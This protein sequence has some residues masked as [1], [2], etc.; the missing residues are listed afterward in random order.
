VNAIEYYKLKF[1]SDRNK[2]F[3]H[4]TKEVGELAGSIEKEKHDMAQ[5]ELVEI[6]GLCYFLAST[7]EMHNVNEKL[8]SVY[9]EKLQKLKG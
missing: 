7:Y 4:L 2:A 1:G 6:L 9:T 8:E 5:Y 3:I